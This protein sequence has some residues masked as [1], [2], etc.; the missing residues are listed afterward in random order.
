MRLLK[1]GEDAGAVQVGCALIDD[2]ALLSSS[3]MLNTHKMQTTT[4]TIVMSQLL[5]GSPSHLWFARRF[6]ARDGNILSQVSSPHSYRRPQV[7]GHG[8]TTTISGDA[9]GVGVG[10]HLLKELERDA[11]LSPGFVAARSLASQG[12]SDAIYMLQRSEG[13]SEMGWSSIHDSLIN[14]E[15]DDRD[16]LHLSPVELSRQFYAT[17]AEAANQELDSSAMEPP[18]TPLT[19]Q[20]R[21][22]LAAASHRDF[23]GQYF[24]LQ[25]VLSEDGV[26]EISEEELARRMERFVRLHFDSCATSY[27]VINDRLPLVRVVCRQ[28]LA[29]HTNDAKGS[30]LGPVAWRGDVV[31]V[32]PP[33]HLT[34]DWKELHRDGVAVM[35][36]PVEEGA[37]ETLP[38]FALA[39]ASSEAA[40]SVEAAVSSPEVSD[41]CLVW[42]E[43]CHS[44]ASAHPFIPGL[45]PDEPPA[46]T[47]DVGNDDF[48]IVETLQPQRSPSLVQGPSPRSSVPLPKTAF[49]LSEEELRAASDALG[50]DFEVVVEATT[51]PQTKRGRRRAQTR[52]STPA[53]PKQ[54]L[55]E[56]LLEPNADQLMEMLSGAPAEVANNIALPAPTSPPQQQRDQQ[57]LTLTTNERRAFVAEP[58][59]NTLRWLQKA[60]AS[61]QLKSAS[62]LGCLLPVLT[63]LYPSLPCSRVPRHDGSTPSARPFIITDVYPASTWGMRSGHE[64][65]LEDL[66]DFLSLED[67]NMAVSGLAE[68][69]VLVGIHDQKYLQKHFRGAFDFGKARQL[70][71]KRIASDVHPPQTGVLHRVAQSAGLV[72]CRRAVHLALGASLPRPSLSPSLASAAPHPLGA[73]SDVVV[74]APPS[75]LD[76]S[77]MQAVDAIGGE[78]GSLSPPSSIEDGEVG[79]QP[80][81]NDE[82][83]LIDSWLSGIKKQNDLAARRQRAKNGG[84]GTRQGDHG[85]A[86]PVCDEFVSVLSTSQRATHQ[87]QLKL[88][89]ESLSMVAAGGRVIYATSSHDP[90]QNEAIVALALRWASNVDDNTTET[91]QSV[92]SFRCVNVRTEYLSPL[93][94]LCCADDGDAVV[95]LESYGGGVLD[96]FV[97]ALGAWQEVAGGSDDAQ[98]RHPLPSSEIFSEGLLEEISSACA[99]LDPLHEDEEGLFIAIIERVAVSTDRPSAPPTEPS[100][101]N[102]PQRSSS[103]SLDQIAQLQC[104]PIAQQLE[105][106]E[107][108]D[109][110]VVFLRERLE[111]YDKLPSHAAGVGEVNEDSPLMSISA[112]V[113]GGNTN[114]IGIDDL[115]SDAASTQNSRVQVVT[116][117]KADEIHINRKRARAGVRSWL[118]CCGLPR[119]V[120][121]DALSVFGLQRSWRGVGDAAVPSTSPKWVVPTTLSG[122]A[123]LH[124]MALKFPDM[125]RDV[126]EVPVSKLLTLLHLTPNDEGFIVGNVLSRLLLGPKRR[127]EDNDQ[128][129]LLMSSNPEAQVKLSDICEFERMVAGNHPPTPP[130]TVTLVAEWARVLLALSQRIQANGAH[131]IG[132]LILQAVPILSGAE[133]ADVALQ[134]DIAAELKRCLVV[135]HYSVV[136]RSEAPLAAFIS[137]LDHLLNAVSSQG[138][139]AEITCEMLKVLRR[140]PFHLGFDFNFAVHQH[141]SEALV[142]LRNSEVI[143][144]R[145]L[146]AKL[147]PDEKGR[148]SA[149]GNEDSDDDAD[150]SGD[151]LL[152]CDNQREDDSSNGR[153]SALAA[154]F[155]DSVSGMFTPRQLASSPLSL[156]QKKALLGRFARRQ[157]DRNAAWERCLSLQYLRTTIRPA[158]QLFAVRDALAYCQMQLGHWLVV[159]R[160]HLEE[161]ARV[162]AMLMLADTDL[163]AN[164]FG[165]VISHLQNPEDRFP[166]TPRGLL[167]PYGLYKG[168]PYAPEEAEEMPLTS[169][170]LPDADSFLKADRIREHRQRVKGEGEILRRIA[171]EM[172]GS[173]DIS[174]FAD[175]PHSRVEGGIPSIF[176][177]EAEIGAP[178][179]SGVPEWLQG[180]LERR[181]SKLRAEHQQQLFTPKKTRRR[182]VESNRWPH[183]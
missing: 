33:T 14:E 136:G 119:C 72:R 182:G 160:D 81:T 166:F 19:M 159:E 117:S 58:S 171:R 107:L 46:A 133:G 64:G 104:M 34:L 50:D 49:E 179:S 174:E 144:K 134:D 153:H 71:F 26:A 109:A 48:D 55:S 68:S 138:R 89:K 103:F 9:L 110:A 12:D 91:Q 27:F 100:Q 154:Q 54:T 116:T 65:C 52:R 15:R 70:E 62:L 149:D 84:G 120:N 163:N 59:L 22:D 155:S 30:V 122:T 80:V 36:V 20:Q 167:G 77:R 28:Q 13:I 8:E 105:L 2:L 162:S 95:A 1:W 123:D 132:S 124:E 23:F 176:E 114:S 18:K 63:G 42:E 57:A 37:E 94:R 82:D 145:S 157:R 161:K 128:R 129:K 86:A 92:P 21:R 146:R 53:A 98:Q 148:K 25:G 172:G 106:P 115:D 118:V 113:D 126:V 97:G 142:D 35:S 96:R 39:A 67:G 137:A 130:F 177:S 108:S 121:G 141:P 73:F 140:P 181:K 150:G 17:L 168:T 180:A 47:N 32:R 31:A 158:T 75:T 3:A 175:K 43:E 60:A 143:D 127:R 99:R 10:K 183:T 125:A 173:A 78:A 152:D 74:C 151:A 66:D 56:S 178:L 7:G 165:N 51:A 147:F 40:P 88:L 169:Q 85:G 44:D 38:G 29:A 79:E 101:M 90:I 4:A 6:S 131:H 5:N 164:D 156:G 24:A 45:D 170:D 76:A 69:T 87:K 93:A 102:E 112:D 135:C 16:E 41:P 11:A 139:G 83:S 111:A 61:G